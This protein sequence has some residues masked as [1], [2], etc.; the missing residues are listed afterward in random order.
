[1]IIP[2]CRKYRCPNVEGIAVAREIGRT[3]VDFWKNGVFYHYRFGLGKATVERIQYFQCIYTRGIDVYLCRSANGLP[4]VVEPGILNVCALSRTSPI[5]YYR[6]PGTSQGINR[7]DQGYGKGFIGS[8]GDQSGVLLIHAEVVYDQLVGA[9][10][11]DADFCQ[12]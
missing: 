10:A 12:S 6:W 1:M 4:Q 2:V 11:F 5:Q 3:K 9:G 8:N 7:G